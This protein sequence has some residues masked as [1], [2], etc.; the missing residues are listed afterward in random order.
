MKKTDQH[1][2]QVLLAFVLV[3]LSF[4]AGMMQGSGQGMPMMGMMHGGMGMGACMGMMGGRQSMMGGR[5]SM[6]LDLTDEQRGRIRDLQRAQRKAHWAQMEK[7]LEQRDRLD[8]L[9]AA[10]KLDAGEIGKAYS[11]LSDLKRQM[12]ESCIAT[13]NQI[14]GLLTDE[15][16]KAYLGSYWG[17]GR[18]GMMGGMGIMH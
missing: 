12:I 15:Q 7:I 16:R 11:A 6:M 17:M 9:Y 14:R 1:F 8:D 2:V 10:D 18:P 13:E 4:T 5:Q 3:T